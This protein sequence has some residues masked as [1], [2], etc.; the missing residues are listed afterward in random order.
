V[1]GDKA[2]HI[3][4][5][6]MGP[7]RRENP[8]RSPPYPRRFPGMSLKRLGYYGLPWDIMGVNASEAAPAPLRQAPIN[9]A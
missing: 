2:V 4:V 5:G 7:A 8:R 1:G 9:E 3:V 6:C